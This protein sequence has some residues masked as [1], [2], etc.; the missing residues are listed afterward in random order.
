MAYKFLILSDTHGKWPYSHNAPIPKADVFPHCGNLT[1]VGGLPS[2]KRAIENIK[3]IHAELK[4]IIAG[5]HDLEL[6]PT[7]AQDDEEADDSKVCIAYMKSLEQFGIHFLDE[8]TH[9]FTLTSG[10]VFTVYASPYTPKFNDGYVFSYDGGEDRF[11]IGDAVMSQGIDIAMTHGPPLFETPTYTLDTD[12]KGTRCGCKKLAKAL[13]HARPRLHCFT[14]IDEGRGAA[15][16]AWHDRVLEALDAH[17]LKI[18]DGI[19]STTLLNAALNEEGDAGFLVEI[20]L[21]RTSC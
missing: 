13:E 17:N 12:E 7:W 15:R 9:T 2:F 19:A 16:M 8:G 14:H 21:E 4:L 18:G 10:H 3:T 20:R 6:D 11:N 5:N 1:Q